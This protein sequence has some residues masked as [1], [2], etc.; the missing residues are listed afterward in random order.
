[1][2]IY[3]SSPRHHCSQ[4]LPMSRSIF[5]HYDGFHLKPLNSRAN[6]MLSLNDPPAIPSHSQSTDLSHSDQQTFAASSALYQLK[7]SQQYR[8]EGRQSLPKGVG[9]DR[10]NSFPFPSS[11]DTLQNIAPKAESSWETGPPQ[12]LPTMPTPP[13]CYWDNG[14]APLPEH[15]F[16][17]AVNQPQ[18]QPY[19]PW[20][21]SCTSD[22]LELS[23][24][25]NLTHNAPLQLS[26][27]QSTSPP[28]DEPDDD[29]NAIDQ[30]LL[31]ADEKVGEV[32]YAQL[33]YRALMN[34]PEHRMVLK[35]I[36]RWIEEN[37]DKAA[38]IM[39][40][41]WQNSVRHNLS[42]NKVRIASLR[43]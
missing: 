7:H 29:S 11:W 42:M 34:A 23:H 27:P 9:D 28:G 4:N 22:R 15:Q 37:T 43:L 2:H 5:D 32:P 40:K 13:I 26:T 12:A 24:M 17:L 18:P 6:T 19:L 10:Q 35:E 21:T 38:D 20:S 33:I 31:D 8:E 39:F 16:N 36:Y 30:D 1:M 41:G 3:S 25:S 14:F